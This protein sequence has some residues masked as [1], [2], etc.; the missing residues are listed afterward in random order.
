LIRPVKWVIALTSGAMLV[1]SLGAPA[2]AATPQVIATVGSSTTFNA[3]GALATQYNG[4][5]TLNP[6][7]DKI[8]NVPPT[9]PSGQSFNVPGDS[10]CAAFSYHN[11]GTLPPNGSSAGISALVADT[12]GCIDSARSSRG[13]NTSDPA[14]LD[15]FAWAIDGVSWAHVSTGGHAPINLNQSQLQGIYLCTNSG[16]PQFTNWNQVGGSTAPIIRYLPQTG[17]GT[18]SFFETKV[19]GLSSAQ[20]GVLDDSS[21]TVHPKRIEENTGTQIAAADRPGAVVPYSFAD[22]TAQKNKVVPDVR[23]GVVLGQINHINP[24][25]TTLGIGCGPCFLGRRYVYNVI[26]TTAPSRAAALAFE[27]VSTSGN[28][29]LCS[30]N[31]TKN[32]TITKYGFVNLPFA[33]AGTGLPNSR[34]RRNP[35]PI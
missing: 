1:A 14:N 35:T 13:R 3:I 33:P 34:C 2:G 11:P 24:T 6:N 29:Y 10:H 23:G 18:L 15:F 25:T 27:G 19:L 7:H 22:W 12:K 5:A 32:S 31:A 4:S 21:C 17:S 8:V 16:K 26:K 20:Q 9:L 28:G 30:N